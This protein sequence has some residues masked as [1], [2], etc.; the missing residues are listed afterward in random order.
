MKLNKVTELTEFYCN[1][2]DKLVKRYSYR[3]GGI[4]NAE[5]VVQ[6]AFTRALTYIDSFDPNNKE[7]AAWFNTICNNS[8]KDFK[9]QERL[10]GLVTQE[11]RVLEHID[12]AAHDEQLIE[13]IIEYVMQMPEP[14]RSIIESFVLLGYAAKEV[15]QLLDINFHT[16][17]K[18]IQLFYEDMRVLHKQEAYT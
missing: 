18:C 14:S 6:E 3:A 5:D 1:N 10:Q 2:L 8:L 16:V 12:L 7:L 11:D 13:E 4:E 9:R 17:R 15:V